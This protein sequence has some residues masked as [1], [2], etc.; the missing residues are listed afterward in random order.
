M[1]NMNFSLLMEEPC[2]MISG[3]ND[4]QPFLIRET[5]LELK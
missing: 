1:L 4:H 5:E 3:S 2:H